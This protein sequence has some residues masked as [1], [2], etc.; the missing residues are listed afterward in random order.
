VSN[1]RTLNLD[2]ARKARSEKQG[3]PP[4]VT[5]DGVDYT[6]PASPPAAAFVALAEVQAGNMTQVKPALAALF[7][8]ENIDALLA[9]GLDLD[10]L[11]DILDLYD[12]DGDGLGEASA[13]GGSSSNGSARS[14]RA[15]KART[16]SN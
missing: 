5:L 6:L 15:S 8:E 1:K 4:V 9:G 2:E 13:S 7:G 14:R 10:D 3:E 16:A 11:G 12:L